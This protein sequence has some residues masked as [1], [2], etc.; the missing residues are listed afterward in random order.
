MYIMKLSKATHLTLEKV[1]KNTEENVNNI[2]E[3]DFSEI[4]IGQFT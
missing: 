1:I 2:E 4:N 3:L